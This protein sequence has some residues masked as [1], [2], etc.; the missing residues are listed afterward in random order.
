MSMQAISLAPLHAERTAEQ[1]LIKR[2][3]NRNVDQTIKHIDGAKIPPK[4]IHAKIVS[5]KVSVR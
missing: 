3:L 5:Q 4:V 1:P 2:F